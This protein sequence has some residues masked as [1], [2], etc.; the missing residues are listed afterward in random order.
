MNGII[1]AVF[2]VITFLIGFAAGANA[3][4]RKPLRMMSQENLTLKVRI[5]K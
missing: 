4:R 3:E 5:K 2:T 1:I